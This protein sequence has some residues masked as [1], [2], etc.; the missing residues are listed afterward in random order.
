MS[1]SHLPFFF[2]HFELYTDMYITSKFTEGLKKLRR[3]LIN[4]SRRND[5]IKSINTDKHIWWCL[6]ATLNLKIYDYSGNK[7]KAFK[8]YK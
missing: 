4:K 5:N 2:S 8:Y 7:R 3:N 1:K 6:G